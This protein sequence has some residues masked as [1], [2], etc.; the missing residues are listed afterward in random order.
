[1]RQEDIVA[2]NA[3]NKAYG[4]ESR[5]LLMVI[6]DLPQDRP[7]DY[8]GNAI[9]RLAN[10]L[11]IADPHVLFLE[12]INKDNSKEREC[13]QRKLFEA[14][15]GMKLTAKVHTK[16]CDITMNTD[17]LHEQLN[18]AKKQQE[19]F[20]KVISLLREDIARSQRDFENYR[21]EAEKNYREQ[22]ERHLADYQKMVSELAKQPRGGGGRTV[23]C[24]IM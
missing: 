18:L 14:F 8:E 3:I 13:L 22:Y 23:L 6:N 11:G 12:R 16:I 4:F 17:T 5:S 20:E 24:S 19:E 21:K 7:R 2:F 15:K 10:I 1:M 9:M